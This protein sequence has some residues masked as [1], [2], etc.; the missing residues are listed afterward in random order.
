VKTYGTLK[1]HGDKWLLNADPHIHLRAKRVFGRMRSEKQDVLWLSHSNEVCRDLDWFLERYPLDISNND[2]RILHLGSKAHRDHIQSLEELIDPSYVPPDFDLVIPARD[3]QRRGAAVALKTTG[4]LIADD[5]GLG[6]TTTSICAMVDPG[7]LPAIVV[8]LAH[9]PRQWE[10]EIKK[11]APALKVHVIRNAM[12][13]ELPKFFGR[14]PDVVIL[15]Y[16]KLAGWSQV[17][18]NYGKLVVFDEVQELRHHDSAKYR[19]AWV[20]ASSMAVRVGLSATPIYNYGGEIFNILNL[21]RPESLGTRDEF[22]TEWCVRGAA[23][24]KASLKD[25]KAFGAWAREQFLIV[26]HRRKEVGRELPPVSRVIQSVD[27]NPNALNQ[28]KSSAAELARLILSQVAADATARWQASQE[29]SNILRQATGIAKAPFVADFVRMLVS[30][31]E[32]VVVFAWHRRVYELLQS[33]LS[34]LHPVMYT[35]SETAKQKDDA[36]ESFRRGRSQVFLMSLR[37]GAGLNGL[38]DVSSVCV[39]AELDW[40]PGVHEQNIGRLARDG[41]DDPVLAYFLVA[42][43]GS[44]PV[45]AQMLG[46]KREQVEGIRDPSADNVLEDLQIDPSHVRRL[47]EHYLKS[48]GEQPVLEEAAS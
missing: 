42:D 19:A 28:V 13:Y 33:K 12:P 45:V 2:R 25:P 46:L 8:T 17:L 40:S 1:L 30:Q 36:L 20:I 18:S 14:G 41:Q 11:F 38:Q 31:G 9:L 10:A 35:G 24:E 27:T 39:F 21:L 3:Y 43:E 6:K 4:V 23:G 47:A 48:I 15:N 7:A 44:D 37:S 22:A 29:L 32:Q 26:R 16:H 34:D 5:V